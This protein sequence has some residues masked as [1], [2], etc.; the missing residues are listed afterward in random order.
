MNSSLQHFFFAQ[1]GAK[2]LARIRVL[3]G[4]AIL[5]QLSGVYGI[6][7]WWESIIWFP[8]HTFGDESVYRLAWYVMPYE[9]F[10][11][12]PIPS[13]ALYGWLENILFYGTILWTIGFF[14]RISGSAVFLLYA[15][16]FL[17]SQLSYHHHTFLTLLVLG[18]LVVAP[19]H[20][21]LSVDS[22]IHSYAPQTVIYRQRLL[23]ILV[24]IIYFFAGA[25]KLIHQWWNGR[26]IE[27]IMLERDLP[28]VTYALST[29]PQ[30]A[31]IV[32]YIIIFTLFFLSFAFRHRKTKYFAL[33][34]GICFH[35][36]IEFFLDIGTFSYIMGVLYL[37]FWKE[38][39]ETSH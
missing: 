2:Q 7:A 17:V 21:Y 1:V 32:S 22:L 10:E 29:Y 30:I 34:V 39:E 18:V 38:E 8:L 12:L 35:I 4:V 24:S 11:R 14:S 3:I 25:A 23:Q 20:R 26:M 31:P 27:K 15:Y 6:L 19:S 28:S 33:V 37:A 16:F 36:G 13:L 5:F 9:W